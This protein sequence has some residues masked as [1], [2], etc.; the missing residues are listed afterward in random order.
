[1][2]QPHETGPADNLVFAYVKYMFQQSDRPLTVLDLAELTDIP[3][4][5][6]RRVVE[7]ACHDGVLVKDGAGYRLANG[8]TR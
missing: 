4:D 8:A 6:I 5:G 3:S 1:M 2:S 7:N